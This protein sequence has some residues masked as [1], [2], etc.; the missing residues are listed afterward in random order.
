MQTIIYFANSQYLYILN[1]CFFKIIILIIISILLLIF[2]GY[3][4]INIKEK[5]NVT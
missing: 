5:T 4:Y 3:K 2:L 1:V